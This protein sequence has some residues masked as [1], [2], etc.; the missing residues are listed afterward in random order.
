MTIYPQTMRTR[1]LFPG[2]K[3]VPIGVRLPMPD[4]KKWAADRVTILKA[5]G[6]LDPEGNPTPRLEVVKSADIAR[7]TQAEWQ[8]DRG[9]MLKACNQCHSMNFAMGELQKGDNMIREAD[10]LMAE[11]IIIIAGLY[12]DGILRKPTNYASAYPDLLTF[13]DAPTVIEQKLFI[14]FLEHRMR[15]FQG[16]FHA[17]PDYSIWYGWSEMRRDLTEIK[18]RAAELRAKGNSEQTDSKK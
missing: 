18:E 15:A 14:M 1:H 16:V 12:Q 9:L 3:S 4:D 11:A 10:S 2:C 7:L 8:K 17:N 5:L 13:H 6:V